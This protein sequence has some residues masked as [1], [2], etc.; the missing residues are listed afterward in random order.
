MAETSHD[1]FLRGISEVVL[2]VEDLDVMCDFYVDVVGLERWKGSS[3]FVFLKVVDVD[4]PV[5]RGSHPQ[6]I[7]LVDRSEH[8]WSWPGI[9]YRDPNPASSSL[10]HLTFEIDAATMEDQRRRLEAAGLDVECVE[11]PWLRARALFFRDPEGNIIEY[12]AHDPE[13]EG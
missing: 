2:R 12:L 6:V 4:T 8:P 9:D 3:G 13:L 7:A 11:F 5:G 1:R 10:D